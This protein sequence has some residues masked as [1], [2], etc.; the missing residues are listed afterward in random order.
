MLTAGTRLKIIAFAVI[1][2]VVLV[3]VGVRYADVGRYIGLREYYVVE[4]ELAETGGLFTNAEVT[5]RGV[6]V[7][8]VGEL[9]LSDDGVV[10]E[11]HID[12]SAPPIPSDARAVVHNLSAVGEQYIDLTPTS[13]GGPFL[14]NGSVIPNRATDIPAPVTS[15]VRS[16]NDL[17]ASVPEESLRTVVDEL[18]RAFSGQGQ[19]LQ[20]LLDASRSLT[21]AA[22][23]HLPQTTRLIIDGRTVLR[24]QAE[25]GAALVSFAHDTRLLA[26]QLEESDADLRRLIRA[27]PRAAEQVT[28]LLRSTDPSLSVMLA[29]L[30]TVSD[31]L[32]TRQDGLEQILVAYPKAVAAGNAVVDGGSLNFGM[33]VTFF[34]PLPC[35]AGYG[36][37]TYRNGLDTSPGPPLNTG[38]RCTM[39]ASSG[40]NVRGSA[41]APSGGLPPV[42]EAGTLGVDSSTPAPG[43][44]LPGALGLPTL[45]PGPTTMRGLLGL[46]RREGTR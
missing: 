24:T 46:P 41:H 25:E 42:A 16:V 20:A 2:V 37:T 40:V 22:S 26:A 15:V 38:A 39:P 27:T 31:L 45:P 28:A 30:L 8:R 43:T 29:N 23:A 44:G 1:A 34:D 13:S 7:G 6:P 14:A 3:Y 35:T 19:N 10:A 36:G 33:A 21:G 18:Y 4:V 12:R 17:A 9:R 32:L 11:L 5:Y